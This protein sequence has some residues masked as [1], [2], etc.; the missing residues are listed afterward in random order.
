MPSSLRRL[1]AT[2]ATDL[3][4]DAPTLC[5]PWS[6]RDLLAHL[7]VRESRPDALPGVAAPV[8]ALQRHTQSVQ[9]RV[10][11]RDFSDLVGQVVDGPAPWWPTRL[12]LLDRMVN[13]AELAVHHE[14]MVRAQPDWQPTDLPQEV[15]AQLWR[16]VRMA[17]RM[18]YRGAPT[19]VVAVAHGHGRVALRRPPD[20]GGTVVLRGTPLELVLHAFGREDHARVVAEGSDADVAALAS[21]RRRL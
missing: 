7:V 15:Q 3:G 5:D 2:T 4:P 18:T 21:H 20:D 16:T 8:K 6:V 13:T 12:P 10:A 9:D 19:G 17:G 14:D 1:I 11:A